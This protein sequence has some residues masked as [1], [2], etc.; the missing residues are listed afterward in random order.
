M[1]ITIGIIARAMREL[2]RCEAIGQGSFA[3]P[4]VCPE[5]EHC[6]SLV[7]ERELW[8]PGRSN[9]DIVTPVA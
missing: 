2:G 9:T 7:C 5:L 3:S 6:Q 4:N 1:Y 8:Q